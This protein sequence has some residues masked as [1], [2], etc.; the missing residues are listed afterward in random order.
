MGTWEEESSALF[1]SRNEIN[2]DISSNGTHHGEGDV[3]VEVEVVGGGECREHESG[4]VAEEGALVR[5][6]ESLEFQNDG[7]DGFMTAEGKREDEQGE[8]NAGAGDDDDDDDEVM[9]QVYPVRPYAADCSFY[10]KVGTCKFGQNCRYNHPLKRA[11]QPIGEYGDNEKGYEE[12]NGLA[13]PGKIECKYFQTPI[14]CK[15]GDACRYVHSASRAEKEYAELNFLGLPIRPSAQE[16]SYYLRYGSCGYGANC[17]FNHPDPSASKESEPGNSLGNEKSMRGGI[18]LPRNYGG[19]PSPSFGGISQGSSQPSSSVNASYG[20]PYAPNT[21]SY[22]QT[23]PPN[24]GWNQ[25][26]VIS[27]SPAN[28]FPL[29]HQ[30]VNNF[31]KRVDPATHYQN[32][33]Q[34]EEFPERPG[35]PDCDYFI[36]TGNCKYRSACRYNHPTGGKSKLPPPP[37]SSKGLYSRPPSMLPAESSQH[38][39]RNSNNMRKNG[40]SSAY[41]QNHQ[42]QNGEFPERPQ[43]PECEHYMRTGQ[44]KFMSAC[45]YHHPRNRVPTAS[46]CALSEKGLPL[47]PG[48]KLCRNY[49]QQGTCKYGPKC[50]YNHPDEYTPEAPVAASF[51]PPFTPHSDSPFIPHSEPPY[52]TNSDRP[53]TNNVNSAWKDGWEM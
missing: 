10:I 17:R 7:S 20:P 16:C 43:Q 18:S 2:K 35:E 26:Q 21:R 24:P 32:L 45:R 37:L 40:M 3:E 42:V 38:F 41:H 5:Q 50:L 14:G 34:A 31:S 39:N 30:P 29:P 4:G 19:E 12:S 11:N 22:H 49:E 13:D 6:F 53:I 28:K 36:K 23:T 1:E 52:A 48:A 27:S 15:Y 44:C 51:D 8:Y 33:T 47:R 46:Q 9:N 25:S